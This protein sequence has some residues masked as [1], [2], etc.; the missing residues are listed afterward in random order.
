MY[1]GICSLKE[2]IKSINNRLECGDN[3]IA[4][5][6]YDILFRKIQISKE[7]EGENRLKRNCFKKTK[8]YFRRYTK[9]NKRCLVLI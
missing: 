9:T 3:F 5:S 8:V 6:K 4:L 2:K 1:T 7:I